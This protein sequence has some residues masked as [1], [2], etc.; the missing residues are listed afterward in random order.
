MMNIDSQLNH[1]KS[2]GHRILGCFPL[3]PPLELFYAMDL[4]P[5]VLWGLGESVSGVPESDRHLQNY[6]CSVAR[7]LT[8]FVL[9]ADTGLFDG[10]FMYNACDTIRNLPE[11]LEAGLAEKGRDI[12][13]IKVHIP[14]ALPGRTDVAGHFK[15]EMKRLIAELE[16]VFDVSFSGEKFR[17]AVQQ[18]REI[19]KRILTAENQVAEG[20]LSFADF[21][22]AMACCRFSPLEDQSAILSALG[23][24]TPFSPEGADARPGV[25]LS[26]ILPPPPSVIQTME[27]AG[28]RIVGND[29]AAL[30]RTY[31]S[32][33][34]IRED[35]EAYFLDFYYQH[36]PCPTLLYAGDRRTFSLLHLIEKTRASG[37]IFVGEK[38][39]EYEYF[40]FPHLMG[41]LKERDIAALELEMAM[42]DGAAFSALESRIQAF[43]E[44][45]K[46]R[47]KP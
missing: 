37:V 13:L 38:F 35:P 22:E 31:A 29:I 39:C 27:A 26:G 10:L 3:Y 34:E 14:M 42:A 36:F 46:E 47:S 23:N 25:I 2:Q 41:L 45:L 17:E 19:R 11:I 16:K 21:A 9:T 40:E 44:L 32:M 8:E 1:L 30:G 5:V 33:P 20:R 28:L 24:G 12:P 18:V 7:Y 43:A 15:N 4:T 6:T